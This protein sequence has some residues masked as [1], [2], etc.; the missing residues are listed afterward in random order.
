MIKKLMISIVTILSAV[1]LSF[2][3]SHKN[4][5]A[6]VSSPVTIRLNHQLSVYGSDP[7]AY[8]PGANVTFKLYDLTND[9]QKHQNDENYFQT[10]KSLNQGIEKYIKQNNV[11]L[12]ET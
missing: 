8:M 12:V 11:Q 7:M 1:L 2:S 3:L 4:V 9:Y 10:L 5:E 6:D